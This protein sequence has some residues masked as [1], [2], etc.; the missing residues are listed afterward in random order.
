MA[1]AKK[2]IVMEPLPKFGR[3]MPIADYIERCVQ[4]DLSDDDGYANYATE[5]QMVSN[6][7]VSPYAASN[8]AFRPKYPFVVWFNR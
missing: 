2:G 1:A 6:R 4:G 3:H 5:D 8:E 7:T